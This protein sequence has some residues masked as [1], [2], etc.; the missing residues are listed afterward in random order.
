MGHR[1]DL[2]P[3][4][5]FDGA[6]SLLNSKSAAKHCW[7]GAGLGCKVCSGQRDQRSGGSSIGEVLASSSRRCG[8]CGAPGVLMLDRKSQD[9]LGLCRRH[10]GSVRMMVDMVEL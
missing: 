2:W 5:Y 6:R 8:H 4:I 3:Q 10:L 9:M 7:I 1:T